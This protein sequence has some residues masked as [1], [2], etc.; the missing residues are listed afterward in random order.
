MPT[1]PD[2]RRTAPP[3]TPLELARE[4]EVTPTDRAIAP[5][6][7]AHYGTPLFRALLAAREEKP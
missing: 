4:A 1:L 3:A 2:P 5:R 6:F 7:W